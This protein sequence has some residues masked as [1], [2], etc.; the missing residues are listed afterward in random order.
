MRVL[1]RVTR[2]VDEG[3]LREGKPYILADAVAQPLVDAGD[4]VD[5]DRPEPEVAVRV[6]DEDAAV[7]TKRKRVRRAR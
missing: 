4:A 3:V 6:A 5:L 1:M 2:R 7:R